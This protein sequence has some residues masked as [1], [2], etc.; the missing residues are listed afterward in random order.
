MSSPYLASLRNKDELHIE[1]VCLGNICRSPM[2]AAILHNKSLELVRPRVIVTSSGTS[3]YHIGDGAHPLSK[4]TW[5]RAGYQYTHVAKQFNPASFQSQD[6]I[7]AMDLSNRALIL[8]ATKSEADREK[9]F[10]LRQFDPELERIDP[11]SRE[12][13]DLQVPDP[14]GEE[15]DAYQEVLEMIERAVNGLLN[16]IR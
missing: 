1:M 10:L 4:K 8:T 3:N 15:I 7:L 2:A 13:A 5:E 6:L 11:I 9:V 16:K 14:W 12:G